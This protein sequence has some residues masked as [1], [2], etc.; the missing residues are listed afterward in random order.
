MTDRVR[1]PLVA[2]PSTLV[3]GAYLAI[4][5]PAAAATTA[6]AP[7]GGGIDGVRGTLDANAGVLHTKRC[8]T[9][10]CDEAG[11]IVDVPIPI[12]KGRL[13]VGH[14]TLDV[15]AIG[16][17]RS[18]LHVRVP[19]LER[20]DLAFEAVLAG[21]SDEPI[22]AGLTGHTRGDEGDRSGDIVL[23]HDRD[24]ASKFVLV[25]E[26]REDT[27]ICG[28]STTPLSARGLDPKTMQLRGATL[29]RIDKK[30]REGA[31][32]IIAQARPTDAKSPLARLLVA[33]GG[34]APAA[35]TLTDGNVDTSWSEKRPGDGHGEFV[36]MRA[37]G[38]MPLHKIVVTMAPHTPKA[39]G[40][41]PRSF[42]VATDAQLF[43]VTMP[44]DAWSKPAASYEI[45]FPTPVK[46]TCL[47]IV[48]DEAYTRGQAAP[49]VSIA[50]A[51]ALSKF[52]LD[53]ASLDDV[54]K[55]LSTN[56][57]DEA[58]A[59]LRRAGD[60]GL[61]AVVKR[62]PDLDPRGRAFGVDVAS[63]AGSCDG[64]AI[65]LLSRGLVDADVEVKKRALGRIER[66]G[67][68]AAQ[69]LAKIV[70]SA[71]EPRRAATA[72]L[73][74]TV[75]PSVA[76][77][78]IG[79]Q[80]G[81]GDP[82]A[83]RAFRGAFARASASASREKLLELLMKRDLP[84]AARLDMLRAA[85]AKLPDLRP[86]SSAA[87]A[88]VLRD[89]GQKPDMAT[90]WLVLQPLAQLARSSDA[91]P[92]ELT[93]L[94][95]MMQR[96]PEWPVRAHAA[97]LAANV[98]PLLPALRG[99]LADPEPRVREA[100]LKSLGA[101][102]AGSASREIG[103]ALAKDTWTFVRVAAAEALGEMPDPSAEASLAAGLDDASPKVRAAVV[104]ALGNKRATAQAPKIRERLDDKKEDAEVRALA[105]RTLGTLCVQGAVDRLTTLASR[106]RSPVDETDDRIGIAAIEALG[107]L[108]PADLEKRLA[109]LRAKEVRLPVR[110]AADRALSEPATCR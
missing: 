78:P 12:A 49:E 81:Q 57:A 44:E 43:H 73:L 74:A 21:S 75:A 2:V 110:R 13:D 62:W 15:L 16:E 39:D 96:D 83:R 31:T 53:G 69:T 38:E 102:H 71:E 7:P 92:G 100:A 85:G 30:G 34:S 29:H 36:T 18:V 37:P 51:G 17:G 95:Q 45:P 91:T 50:E 68:N 82:A 8:K 97:E 77:E 47:A 33:T 42:F 54:T 63:S 104:T 58:A 64:T 48:L 98:G 80:L 4:A 9:P 76:L 79:E 14:A 25:A 55:E 19:D 32:R 88:D 23:V 24:E 90:R 27:R 22:F 26:A 70:R 107:A 11:K 28:Q 10:A 87:I 94:A 101:S 6:F 60:D 56:R 35:G 65:D 67:K 86:Q 84:A 105:A 5:S 59:L 1:R 93:R 89:E 106:A 103:T 46:T 109:P 40:A 41:A 66:C 20:K 52:D 108:H 3:A 61:A 72:P 99:A